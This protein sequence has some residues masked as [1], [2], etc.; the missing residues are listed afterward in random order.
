M[1]MFVRK[2]KESKWQEFL[3]LC[4]DVKEKRR[5]ITATREKITV[6]CQRMNYDAE[7]PTGCFVRYN[8]VAFPWWTESHPAKDVEFVSVCPKIGE[9][10]LCHGDDDECPMFADYVHYCWAMSDL[11]HLKEMRRDSLRDLFRIQRKGR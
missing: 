8:T 4:A 6:S 2:N 11:E 7:R 1:A 10:G 3:R 5:D 9:Y